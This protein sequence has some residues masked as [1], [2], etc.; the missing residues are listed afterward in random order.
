[1]STYQRVKTVLADGEWHSM[2]ELKEVCSFPDRWIEE[3]R[4]DG[5]D[6]R[7]EEHEGKIAL[8]GAAC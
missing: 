4:K 2:D 1:M 8:V 7:E 3:L 5:I 6:V